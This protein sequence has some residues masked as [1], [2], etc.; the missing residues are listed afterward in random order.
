MNRRILAATALLIQTWNLTLFTDTTFSE[1]SADDTAIPVIEDNCGQTASASLLKSGKRIAERLLSEGEVRTNYRYE[2][3]MEACLEFASATNDSEL[4]KRTLG[5]I[6]AL[7]R[8]SDKIVPWQKEPFGSLTYALYRATNDPKWLEA[9][10]IESKAMAR[11]VWRNE[12]GAILHPRGASRGGGYA[13]LIDAMQEYSARMARASAHSDSNYLS[14]VAKQWSL[15]RQQLRDPV[16]G[17][18]SQGKGW[19]AEDPTALSPGAWSRGHGWML[20]GLVA[21]LREMP[22]GH[23]ETLQVD[24]V[25]QE[26]CLSLL[27]LQ[28]PDGS[29]HTLLNRPATQ[30]PIDVSG[31]SMIATAFS[32]GFRRGWLDK[33]FRQGADRSF[34][35]LPKYVNDR[36]QVCSVS[37]GP[38]PLQSEEDYLVAEF[39]IDNDHGLF[40][41]LFAAAE[42]SYASN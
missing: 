5:K 40:S 25:F 7:G 4:R 2:L 27:K 29:W 31:T 18:W 6:R 20:R 33:R 14:E 30:S 11:E 21:T 37:P 39:P 26:L 9:F 1:A 13:M 19:L 34:V 28:Q 32:E 23:Q 8:T 3:G 12:D 41:V 35:L 16:R 22:P 38:G 36:G 24:R 10:L 15:Y 17:T 42:A